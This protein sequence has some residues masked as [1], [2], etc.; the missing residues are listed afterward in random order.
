VIRVRSVVLAAPGGGA[1]LVD[2]AALHIRR[3]EYV[4]LIGPNGA[5]KSLLLQILAGLRAPTAG[6]FTFDESN[7]SCRR[8]IVFQNP[9]DQ[10][11]GS[12][13]ERDLAFGLESREVESAEIRRR[14]DEALEWS[15]LA[16]S[17]RR[18]PHLLSDGEKQRLALAASLLLE[19]DL[20]LL[21]EPTSRLD[22]P[23]RRRFLEEVCR[24]RERSGAA[25]V[26]VS[27]RSEEILP[28]DRVV[29]MRDGRIVFDGS[30]AELLASGDADRLGI[31]WS[32][33]HRLRRE[34]ARHGADLPA[35][36]GEDWNRAEP[37]VG[38]LR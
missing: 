26:Q 30:P 16:A 35:C 36:R 27:H 3:S 22:P 15:G 28:A 17:A 11:V 34:L 23:A 8:A 13:V 12:T 7:G 21:D 10:I 6:E 2:V 5:G 24:F 25:I 37:L 4:S 29:G 9:D 32:E 33:L 1:A 38:S 18:P 31:V 20:L 14:V 19:P